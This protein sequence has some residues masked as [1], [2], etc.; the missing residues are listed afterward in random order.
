MFTIEVKDGKYWSYC[1]DACQY[2]DLIGAFLTQRC[3]DMEPIWFVT[4]Y[5]DELHYHTINQHLDE[6]RI[7]NKTERD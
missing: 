1:Y 5:R 7:T 6:L 2:S 3:H 4:F